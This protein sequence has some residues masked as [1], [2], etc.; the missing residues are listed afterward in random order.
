MQ[1]QADRFREHSIR[2]PDIEMDDALRAADPPDKQP[3]LSAPGTGDGCSED[4]AGATARAGVEPAGNA[5]PTMIEGPAPT[6]PG[7]VCQAAP[8]QVPARLRA[9]RLPDSRHE[10]DGIE[11]H[12]EFRRSVHTL[13]SILICFRGSYIRVTSSLAAVVDSYEVRNVTPDIGEA[14]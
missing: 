9:N 6:N 11:L 4:P 3:P 14:S 7:T 5:C 2:E 10:L 13:R 8:S 12:E 1:H